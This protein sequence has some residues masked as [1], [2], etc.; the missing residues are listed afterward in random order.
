MPSRPSRP[1]T[2]RRE[3]N[4]AS[5]HRV[6]NP[7]VDWGRAVLDRLPLQGDETVIDAGCGTGRLTEL[8]L[9]RLP[10]GRVIAM[11]QSANMLDQA[12]AHLEPRFGDRVS[13]RQVDLTELDARQVADAI[14]ST[15]TFHW[16]TDH[17]RLF[18]ALHRALKPGGWLVAQCGGGPNIAQLN[19]QAQLLLRQEPFT[20]HVGDWSGPWLFAQPDETALRLL[21]VGFVEIDTALVEAPV[22]LESEAAFREFLTT[23][24]FGTHLGRLP[25]EELRADFIERL[26]RWSSAQ[27]PPW[28]LDY[29]RLNITA[30]RPGASFR[31]TLIC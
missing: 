18:A 31:Q 5:Y 8:L 11:D 21:D 2:E 7:H 29:W 15:A 1:A 25:T 27:V 17:A 16:I 20:E 4:A 22:T 23:V 13:F 10:H 6:A 12:R 9:E 30:R 26:V 24:V 14:F 19:R 3:W 28:H